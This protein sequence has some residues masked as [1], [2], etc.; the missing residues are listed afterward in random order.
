[1]GCIVSTLVLEVI[2]T[3][4]IPCLVSPVVIVNPCTKSVQLWS[5][6]IWNDSLTIV[7]KV[8]NSTLSEVESCCKG[9]AR[10]DNLVVLYGRHIH[11]TYCTE[12]WTSRCC[13]HRQLLLSL[14]IAC[15]CPRHI[16]LETIGYVEEVLLIRV[17]TLVESC[18][19]NALMASCWYA[20]QFKITFLNGYTI[21]CQAVRH[22]ITT[23]VIRVVV[24]I[25]H[26]QSSCLSVLPTCTNILVNLLHLIILWLWSLITEDDT[27]HNKLSVVRRITEVTTVSEVT[28]AVL[29]VVI[30][31]LVNPIPDG[32]TH[33]EV[34]RL[35][36]LPVVNE[37]TNSVT[38]RMGILRNM[39]RILNTH[40]TL[41]RITGPSDTWILV[42]THVND[43]VIALILYWS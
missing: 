7:L 34:G 16:M 32:T 11:L 27:V 20:T 25:E 6:T 2:Q 5:T 3:V 26:V 8:I 14:N 24:L 42:R 37:V 12:S 38:H 13:L 1:M 17:K 18:Y 36:C 19:C 43:V 41:H 39:E 28:L 21:S 35:H 31:T 23:K 4:C 33:K 29:C 15:L 22:G 9:L 10:E 30:H 40:L